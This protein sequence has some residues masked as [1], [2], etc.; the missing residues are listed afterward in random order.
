MTR[1]NLPTTTENNGELLFYQTEDGLTRV[2]V[3]VINESVWL[4]QAQIA[5]L[6]QRGRSVITKHISN[7][8]DEGELMPD[9]VCA[10]FA[11]TAPDGKTYQVEHYNLDVIIS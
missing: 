4:T 1:T 10:K 7:V 5:D 6:F 11:H 9:S 2:E 8:F 3:R